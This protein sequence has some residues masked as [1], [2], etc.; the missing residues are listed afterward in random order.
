[1]HSNQNGHFKFYGSFGAVYRARLTP[2]ARE[3]AIAAGV[4]SFSPLFQDDFA[5]KLCYND[6]PSLTYYGYRK[7]TI[8]TRFV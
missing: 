4:P 1:M 6:D 7:G 5:L 2:V 8:G 3:R